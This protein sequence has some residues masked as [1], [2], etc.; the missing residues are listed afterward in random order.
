MINEGAHVRCST[1]ETSAPRSHRRSPVLYSGDRSATRPRRTL[2]YGDTFIVADSHGDIG[3]CAGGP[4][5]LFH[6]DTRFLS[7]LELLHQ[8]LQPLLL[9]SNVRDDNTL[10]DRRPDQSRTSSPTAGIS[11]AEGHR[12]H[13][14]H[15]LPLAR[16]GL[17]APRG[18]QSR[19]PP[20]RICDCRSH[21]GSDFADLFEVRGMRRDGAACC[22]P[23][24]SSASDQVV[25]ELSGPRWTHTRAPR[26]RSIRRPTKLSRDLAPYA[27]DARAGRGQAASSWPSLATRWSQRPLAVPARLARGASRAARRDPWHDHGRDLERSVQRGAVPLGRRPCHADDRHA[28]GAL[29]LCRHSLVLDHVRPRRP[30]HGDADAVVRS[31]HRARRAAPARR[32]PG[33]RPTIRVSDAEPGKILHEMRGGRN[34]GAAARCRSAS[35]TAA[36]MR[37]RCSCCLPASMPSAP[38]TW[39]RCASCGPPSRP[40]C[41]WIDGPGDRGSATASS[42]TTGQTEQGL[43]N[44]GWKDSYD[45]IFHADGRLAEGPIALA[46]VQGYVYRGQAAAARCARRLGRDELASKLEAEA[47]PARRALRGGVLV[48]GARDLCAGA[49]RREAALP[50]PHLECRPGAVHRH[51]ACR[52]RAP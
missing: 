29:S 40:R 31:R 6:C 38:A 18:A 43:A 37:R 11:A 24:R 46:E 10:L 42:S 12:A 39:R 5:G 23:A 21:F 26:C 8:R 49:R 30:D 45:A 52:A 27:S 22:T 13:R 34:G 44:Q 50:G 48:P 1:C 25:A 32:L 9:G 17:S 4:D 35:T 33:H 28:R 19:Q 41:G 47:R 3:A 14:A 15:D 36:S 51:R 16:H 20:G 7:R 2:K